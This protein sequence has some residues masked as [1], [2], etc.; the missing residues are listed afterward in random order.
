M[1]VEKDNNELPIPVNYL[2]LEVDENTEPPVID[3]IIKFNS[4][5]LLNTED[6]HIYSFYKPITKIVLIN[7]EQLF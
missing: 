3:E 7:D 1:K 2:F 5:R 4:C 6:F